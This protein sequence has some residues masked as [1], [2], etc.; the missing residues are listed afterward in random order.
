MEEEIKLLINRMRD[1][2]EIE[3][4]CTEENHVEADGI[5]CDLLR[6]LGYEEIV[7]YFYNVEKWYS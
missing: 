7:K 5:L 3:S 6:K 1:L 4:Y 2:S